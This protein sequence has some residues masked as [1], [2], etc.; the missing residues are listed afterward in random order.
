[1]IKRRQFLSSAAAVSAGFMGLRDFFAHSAIAAP[2]R[3]GYGAPRKDPKGI[4]DLPEGFRYSVISRAGDTMSDALKVPE[5][6]DGMGAFPGPDGSVILLRN[7]E[8]NPGQGP[9]YQ[10]QDVL[11]LPAGKVY[12]RGFGKNPAIGGVTTVIVD[13]SHHRVIRQHMSL[14]GTVHN[15]AGGSTPWGSWISCEESVARAGNQLEKDH[16]YC[17]EVPAANKGPVDPLPIK[18]MGRFNHEAIAYHPP[19]GVIYLTEDRHD[20]LI[21]RYLPKEK[22]NLLAGGKLQALAILDQASSVD[23]RNWRE[24]KRPLLAT[25][26]MLAVRWVDVENID[27]P[28]D[29][30]RLR[31]ATEQGAAVFARGEGIFYGNDAIYWACTN[32]GLQKGGQIFRYVPSPNEGRAEESKQPGQ[33]ELFVE[34]NNSK[35]LKNADNLCV[36]P[37]GDLIVCEDRKGTNSLVGITPAGELY[38]FARVSKG[39]SE[40]AGSIFSPDGRTLFVNV[41]N[42]GLTLAISGPWNG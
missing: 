11:S 1:M 5:K 2:P 3:I 40:F 19:S 35:L 17:F 31:G 36:S 26:K 28:A 25:G 22:G 6:C 37:W 9:A 33:L 12:D 34:P 30:L 23:T 8:I 27:A 41:Q 39:S 15:C 21:Y 13:K 38:P 4:L 16:G 14:A 20:G 32:G 29:D 7:H 18:A 24:T 42:Q 10:T